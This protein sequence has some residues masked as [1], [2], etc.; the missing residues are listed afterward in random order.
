MFR[1]SVGLILLPIAG[2]VA[3]NTTVL[4]VA[5]KDKINLAI[6]L[7]AGIS[8]S[9]L[10][11]MAVTRWAAGKQDKELNP[12]P[13]SVIM[14]L[15]TLL[16]SSIDA[17]IPLLMLIVAVTYVVADGES[18]WLEGTMLM[19]LYIIVAVVTWFFQVP[20]RM[21]LIHPWRRWLRFTFRFVW[22]LTIASAE[23]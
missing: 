22:A 14:P 15:F 18:R 9:V 20:K 1:Y 17:P 3:E 19:V 11:L 12:E 6:G 10:P 4:T 16:F 23:P 13:F 2:N 5:C 7:V 21:R 8:M